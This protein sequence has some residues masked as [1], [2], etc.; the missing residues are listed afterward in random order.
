MSLQPQAV[1]LVPEETARVAR[2]VFR[3]PQRGEGNN[4]AMRMRDHLGAI[5]DDQQFADLFSVTGQP[6]RSPHRLALTTVLQFAEG[7]SDQQAA[8]AVRTRIDWKY[9]LSL[10]LTD[11]GFDS[12][13]LCEFRSRL[14]AGGAE[15]LLFETMLTLFRDLGLLKRRGRQRTDSTHVLAA[16]QRL[17]RLELLGETLRAALNSLAVVAPAWLQALAPPEWYERYSERCE[18]YR[19]P[20]ADSARQSLAMLM[21]A[22]GF[23]LL[24]AVYHPDAPACLRTVPAV[25]IVRRVWIQ[26]LYGPHQLQWRSH[27]DSP[28]TAQV[29]CSPYDTEA[30]Y[31]TKRDS[32]WI[33]YKVHLTEVCDTDAPHLITNVTTTSATTLDVATTASIHQQLA[34]HDRLPDVHFMDAGYVDAELVVTGQRMHQVTVCGPV[35]VETS[36]QARAEKGYAASDFTIDWGAKRATCPQGQVSTGWK[37]NVDRNGNA[38]VKITFPVTACGTC[39]VR[40]DCTRAK[41]DGREL[42]VRT[43]AIHTALQAARQQQAT[44]GFWE[45]YKARAGVEGTLSQGIRR[46]DLRQ[47]RYLGAAKTRLQHLLIATALN[48]IRVVAWYLETPL[49]PT[50]QSRFACLAPSSA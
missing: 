32:T 30:R 31:G 24:E 44:A 3:V 28:P 49:A 21:A 19:L 7:L 39:Q 23:T 36:W 42:T 43:E 16:V 46:C 8:D 20:D 47:A 12:S 4:L 22:D 18:N 50:R 9:A 48:V 13:I 27:D 25:E 14:I 6:A 40:T 38:V 26:Q 15:T 5:F 41:R 17:C 10:E 29:I 35:M 45:A 11:P 33:G 34:D 1:Y 2:A 37:T